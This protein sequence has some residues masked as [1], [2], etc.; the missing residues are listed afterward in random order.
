MYRARCGRCLV[1]DGMERPCDR[2]SGNNPVLTLLILMTD[3]GSGE[4]SSGRGG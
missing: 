1:A 3:V 2:Y 4:S